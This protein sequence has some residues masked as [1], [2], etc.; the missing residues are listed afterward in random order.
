MQSRLDPL[1]C[2]WFLSPISPA[3]I[4]AARMPDTPEAGLNPAPTM[5]EILTSIRRIIAD[6]QSGT[7]PA[8]APQAPESAPVEAAPVAAPPESGA[9]S[10]EDA[11]VP[12]PPASAPSPPPSGATGERESL[13]SESSILA[14]TASLSALAGAAAERPSSGPALRLGD[15]NRTLESL[16]RELLKPLM[17][18]WLD[19]NLPSIVD[20]HVQREIERI[21]RRAQD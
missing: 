9:V 16:V 2:A 14:A 12:S 3:P 17:K 15:G 10:L 19:A 7:P 1:D 6:D 4:V 11:P 21:A 18:E 5:E 8:E 20:R 13:V